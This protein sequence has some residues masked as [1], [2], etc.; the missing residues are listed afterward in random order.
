M[1]HCIHAFR[2]GVDRFD[3]LQPARGELHI[4]AG[5]EM[6]AGMVRCGECPHGVSLSYEGLS[7]TR[8]D[9]TC[10]AGDENEHDP[11]AS[12]IAPCR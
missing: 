1:I 8:S 3:I 4:G 2:R 11:S 7:E 5:D 10:G 9:S 12:D 6:S